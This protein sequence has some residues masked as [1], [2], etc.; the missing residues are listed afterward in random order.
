MIEQ[1]TLYIGALVV[2][3]AIGAAV[4]GLPAPATHPGAPQPGTSTAPNE[5]AAAWRT[6]ELTD[7]RTG[8]TFTIAGFDRPVLVESFAVWCPT[9]TRQQKEIQTLHD[10]VGDDIV[11]VSVDTD[12]NEDA[13]KV[14]N[15]IQ[16]HGFDWRYVV[17]QPAFLQSLIDHFGPSI[18]TAPLSPIVV[19]C[20]DGTAERLQNGVKPASTLR[21]EVR[22]RC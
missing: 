22:Q 21:R 8:E 15:H 11:S 5:T 14:R 17:A 4:V 3:A 10:Q 18:T 9:C 13:A 20:P 1:R 19:V 16:K 2:A 12:P 7:V 6:A